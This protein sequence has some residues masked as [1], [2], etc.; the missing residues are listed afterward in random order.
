MKIF[1][2]EY[3]DTLRKQHNSVFL[4]TQHLSFYYVGHYGF[5]YVYV[6]NDLTLAHLQSF[7]I[8]LQTERGLGIIENK[9]N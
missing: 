6:R 1:R 4:H 9:K 2:D 5:I 3:L 7:I 8:N